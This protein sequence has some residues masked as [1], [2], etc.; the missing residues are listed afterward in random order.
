MDWVVWASCI[1]SSR[2]S[3]HKAVDILPQQ[4]GGGND[5][6]YFV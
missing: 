1:G 5:C 3:I 4:M 2:D 6:N